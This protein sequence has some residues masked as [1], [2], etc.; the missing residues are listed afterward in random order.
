MKEVYFSM[1]DLKMA[2]QEYN[3]FRS[4][5]RHRIN[6]SEEERN[7]LLTKINSIE[8]Q[9]V[10]QKITPQKVKEQGTFTADFT[11]KHGSSFNSQLP[12]GFIK[13]N[14]VYYPTFFNNTLM[15]GIEVIIPVRNVDDGGSLRVSRG[16]LC[17]LQLTFDKGTRNLAIAAMKDNGWSA[18]AS[19]DTIGIYVLKLGGA[20]NGFMNWEGIPWRDLK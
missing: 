16:A 2:I 5:N 19:N 1:A 4:A 12:M 20:N 9:L 6:L 11:T 14:H 10:V 3:N 8:K 13:E 18:Y 7:E 17:Y 15:V